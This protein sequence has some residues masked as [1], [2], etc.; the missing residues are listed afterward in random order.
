MALPW[1]SLSA[2]FRR[3]T[4]PH[5]GGP[6]SQ[7]VLYV[8][9]PGSLVCSGCWWPG[10]SLSGGLVFLSSFVKQ[11]E[12]CQ[13][14]WLQGSWGA[15]GVGDEQEA[16]SPISLDVHFSGLN[17]VYP[18]FTAWLIPFSS[19]VSSKLN[20]FYLRGKECRRSYLPRLSANE[21][22]W[23]HNFC[24]TFGTGPWK[25]GEQM[26]CGEQMSWR[27]W[28]ILLRNCSLQL[29]P[30]YDKTACIRVL[31]GRHQSL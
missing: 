31:G 15:H 3:C 14:G 4:R 17:F 24:E 8:C 23:F 22:I 2:Y 25:P 26:W 11:P 13:W 19:H 29:V 6:T 18:S 5:L 28:L 20:I 9:S 10:T 1:K 7:V 12:T 16:V 30:C 27:V 21:Y